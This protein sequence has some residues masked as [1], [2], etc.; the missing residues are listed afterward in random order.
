M[1]S[2]YGEKW[3]EWNIYRAVKSW[4]SP[5][6]SFALSIEIE[7]EYGNFLPVNRFFK[8][9]NC[10]GDAHMSNDHLLFYT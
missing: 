1:I 4:R 8:S 10:T 5:V 3:T 6:R 7:D 9:M 2:Y